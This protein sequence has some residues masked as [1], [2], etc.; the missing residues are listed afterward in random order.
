VVRRS[1]DRLRVTA[2]AAAGGP[3]P[4]RVLLVGESAAVPA[5]PA[6]RWERTAEG[7]LVSLPGGTGAV[8]LAPAR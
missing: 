8:E 7:T 2:R 4:W 6:V 1:G 5:D 3:A